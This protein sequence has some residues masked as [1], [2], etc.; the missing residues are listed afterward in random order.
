MRRGMCGL[1]T[2]AAVWLLA[3]GILFAA[4][5]ENVTIKAAKEYVEFSVGQE[6]VARYQIGPNVAK[7]YLWPLNGPGGVAVT[8]GWPMEKTKDG[9]STDHVHQKSVWFG[10]GDVIPEG[11]EIKDKRKGVE[12][13]DFWAEGKGTGT[14][15][16]TSVDE[17]KL[18]K[19]HGQITTHNE[20]CA[21]SPQPFS[22]ATGEKGSKGPGIKILDETR[23]IHLYNF[24]AARLFVFEIDLHA[25]MMPITFGDTK[26]GAFA[27]RVNDAISAKG[28][29]ENAEG[30]TGEWNCWG[31]VSKW[32]DYSGS[33]GGTKVGLAIFDDP[34]NPS[35]ACWHTRGYGLHAA[36]P[37]G[38][39]KSG[40]PAMNGKT[41]LVKLPKG[42]H[43]KLRYGLLI[44]PGDAQ[45]GKVAEYC[46]KFTEL[47]EEV[48]SVHAKPATLSHGCAPL[49][50][51]LR[52]AHFCVRRFL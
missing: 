52:A 18:D 37:F 12:G 43:L 31:Q 16:C 40:F 36:N 5:P 1:L 27:V 17:P 25:S 44:H 4:E 26:E 20:W 10:H 15:V 2:I 34:A 35:P 7:P 46:Q 28:K 14:I 29:I 39:A 8:R 21:P 33:V 24:G 22:P 41:D 47:R 11:L 38:R 9:G 13:I 6:L 49:P 23:T 48:I 3:P 50:V 30:K 19:N 45:E 51:Q 32:C 42:D